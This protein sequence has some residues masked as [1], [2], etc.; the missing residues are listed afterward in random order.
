VP[1]ETDAGYFSSFTGVHY[2][3]HPANP[4]IS[5][6]INVFGIAY[7][8]DRPLKGE[9]SI[10]ATDSPIRLGGPVVV[11]FSLENTGTEVFMVTLQSDD[12][13]YSM[14][15]TDASRQPVPLTDY[16]KRAAG[17][18]DEIFRNILSAI[19]PGDK[20]TTSLDLNKLYI[21][22]APGTFRI[23][24]RRRVFRVGNRNAQEVVS[25]EWS[26]GILR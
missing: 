6:H 25:P 8:D 9:I 10:H 17:P 22:N 15:L 11:E 5:R 24:V 14:A 3:L 19:H 1:K 18:K 23:T 4:T 21:F 26:F 20:A 13:D 7:M 2:P 16:G 12:W